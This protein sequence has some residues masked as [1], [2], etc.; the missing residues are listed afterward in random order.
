MHSKNENIEIIINDKADENKE[1]LFKS[2][3]NRYQNNLEQIKDSNFVFDYIYLLHYKCHKIN[4]NSGGS[5]IDS[6]YWIK[7]KTSITNPFKYS[8]CF[9]YVVTVVLNHEEIKKDWQRITKIKSFINKCNLEGINVPSEKDDWKKFEE[10]NVTI[11]LNDLYTKKEK[12]IFCLYFK[13]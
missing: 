11:A 9:Q 10:N 2:L 13:T 12:N 6:P 7:N 3:K 1:E 8:K 4:S 5:Y